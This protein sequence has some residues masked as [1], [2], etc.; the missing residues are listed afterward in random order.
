MVR[1]SPKHA[2]VQT[3]RRRS[4]RSGVHQFRPFCPV[5]LIPVAAALCES[6]YHYQAR[7]RI[8]DR[9][10]QGFGLDALIAAGLVEADDRAELLRRLDQGRADAARAARRRLA[11]ASVELGAWTRHDRDET[12][13]E[14]LRMKREYPLRMVV[15]DAPEPDPDSAAEW[16]DPTADPFGDPV[17]YERGEPAPIPAH[18]REPFDPGSDEDGPTD[19]QW[20]EIYRD[21]C[22]EFT[23]SGW[24]D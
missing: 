13:R 21:R 10:K 5:G 6:S 4:A 18:G 11:D 7:H 19:A 22:P 1:L 23:P 15:L 12:R 14:K 24:L 8:I 16:N 9:L 2:A 3:A 20:E 17:Y